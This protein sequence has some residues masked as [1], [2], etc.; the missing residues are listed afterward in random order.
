MDFRLTNEHVS[1]HTKS[2]LLSSGSTGSELQ[3]RQLPSTLED[4]IDDVKHL[5]ARLV[6]VAI[7]LAV[8]VATTGELE[9][10]GLKDLL[11]ATVPEGAGVCVYSVVGGLADEAEGGEV[12]VG[13]EVGGDV[14]V[15][16]RKRYQYAQRSSGG[17]AEI[18]SLTSIGRASKPFQ[19]MLSASG[20]VCCG[21]GMQSC[22]L[23]SFVTN[24]EC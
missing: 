23:G 13:C 2:L 12:F 14:L 11:E 9:V 21:G 16:L 10:G 5:L 6:L 20:M 3:L 24:G 22:L 18:E 19:A 4:R 17:T 7:L 1:E 8:L 15:E